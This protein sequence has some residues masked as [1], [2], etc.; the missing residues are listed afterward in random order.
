VR[1]AAARAFRCAGFSSSGERRTSQRTAKPLLRAEERRM[2]SDNRRKANNALGVFVVSLV[3]LLE[4]SLAHHLRPSPASPYVWSVIVLVAV[5]SLA[6]YIRF[7]RKE[8]SD[9]G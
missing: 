4:T 9:A 2:Q 7:R 8:G 6:L 1:C 5:V 3:F